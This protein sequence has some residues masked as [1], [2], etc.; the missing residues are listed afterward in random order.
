MSTTDSAIITR[1]LTTAIERQASDIHLSAGNQP[2]IRRDGKLVTL[3]EEQV[4][5]ADFLQELVA[6]FLTEEKQAVLSQQKSVTVGYNLGTRARFR[7]H[8][9]YQKGYPTFDLRYIP[10]RVTPPQTLGLPKGLVELMD[11]R[12]GLIVV[13]GPMGSGRTTT[14]ASLVDMLNHKD[15][16]HVV[17][18][19]DPVEY[20]LVN[21]KSLIQQHDVGDDVPNLLEAVE[22]LRREDVDVAVVDTELPFSVW[23]ELL[24]LAGAGT[25]VVAVVEADSAVHALEYLTAARPGVEPETLRTQLAEVLLGVVSQRLLPRL[26]GGRVLVA[27]LLLGTPPVKSLIRDGKILQLQSVMDTSREEGM[28]SL[29]RGLANL[30]KNGDVLR[31]EALAQAVQRD[32]LESLLR[33]K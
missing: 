12:E 10:L 2:V 33:V 19:E 8:V 22:A 18:I 31:E 16:K 17:L 27:E 28:S 25:L 6:F 20:V 11:A 1:I 14:V 29:E 7:V 5:S 21:D 24:S 32:M 3:V 4:M 23:T 26:G 9:G 15:A 13:S 30:V